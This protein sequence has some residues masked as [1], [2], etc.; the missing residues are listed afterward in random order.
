MYRYKYVNPYTHTLT[1]THMNSYPDKH[2]YQGR[3]F[4]EMNKQTS[5]SSDDPSVQKVRTYLHLRM[6]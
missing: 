6:T 4:T 2:T 3:K 1:Q 5:H